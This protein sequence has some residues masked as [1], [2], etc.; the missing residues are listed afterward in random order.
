MD[1]WRP[2][3]GVFWE[4]REAVGK[5]ASAGPFPVCVRDLVLR[6]SEKGQSLQLALKHLSEPTGLAQSEAVWCQAGKPLS[7]PS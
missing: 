1:L 4:S 5:L 6:A 7:R 3:L 2:I